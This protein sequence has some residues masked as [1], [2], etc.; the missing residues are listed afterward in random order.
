MAPLL[1]LSVLWL[2]C[3]L[4]RRCFEEPL[5]ALAF[6]EAMASACFLLALFW[7]SSFLPDWCDAY[8]FCDALG[9]QVGDA[10]EEPE[11]EGESVADELP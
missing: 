4:P 10:L 9:V 1:E 5:W 11:L 8:F 6:R 7:K 2:E 3:E